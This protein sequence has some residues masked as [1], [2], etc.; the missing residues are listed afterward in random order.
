[1]A[2]IKAGLI[3]MSLK[4][5][6]ESDSPDTIKKKMLDAHMALIEDAARQGV[7]VLGLQEIFNIPYVCASHDNKW[8][9]TAEAIPGGPTVKHMQSVAKEH[10][11]VMVVPIYEEQM[12]GVYYN[13]AAVIDADGSYLGKFR[14]I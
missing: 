10:G 9:A 4:G 14:K 1:M 7:Q 2:V 5:D 3:Q 8:Y 12:A 11:M 13:S 6:V